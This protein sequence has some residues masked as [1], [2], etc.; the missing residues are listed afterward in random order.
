MA[1]CVVAALHPRLHNS[2]RC[3]RGATLFGPIELAVLPLDGKLYISNSENH[4][5]F[6][7]VSVLN[8][9]PL[10]GPLLEGHQ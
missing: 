8:A 6:K 1:W 10:Y 7:I 5:S 3:S 4:K 2:V 9:Q